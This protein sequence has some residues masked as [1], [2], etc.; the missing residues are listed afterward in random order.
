MSHLPT[1]RWGSIGQDVRNLQA[2][3]N[4]WPGSTR[5][6]LNADGIFGPKTNA[7]VREYQ[8]GN[9]LVCDGIV[10]PLTWGAL[11][12]LLKQI[13][14]V[15]NIDKTVS[16]R[17][18]TAANRALNL[19]GWRGE[20]TRNKMLPSIA[21]AYCADPKDPFRPRQGGV[22]L[23]TIFQGA[24]IYS[25][26]CYTITAKAEGKWQAPPSLAKQ[27]WLNQNDLPAWCG[28]FCYFVYFFAGINTGGWPNHS[29]NVKSGRFRVISGPENAFEGCIGRITKGNHHFIVTKNLPEESKILSIDGNAWGPEFPDNFSKGYRSVI[30]K[31]SY[32]YQY[33]KSQNATFYFPDKST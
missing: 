4:L 11:A 23:A 20:V 25:A 28:I 27:T 29:S 30:R 3:L 5:Q 22:G 10:G 12:E 6:P 1:L 8:Q 31:R 9:H 33:L 19:W 16:G 24:G 7:R 18:V 17:I 21:A 32:T 14:Q 15:T 2:A 13:G 26:R